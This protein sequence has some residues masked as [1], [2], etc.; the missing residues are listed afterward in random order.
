MNPD[1]NFV[2][3]GSDDAVVSESSPEEKRLNE[4]RAKYEGLISTELFGT[5]LFL[6]PLTWNELD[7]VTSRLSKPEKMFQTMAYVVDLCAV[8]PE[9]SAVQSLLRRYP[10]VVMNLGNKVLEAS[11]FIE[12][13]V[14]KY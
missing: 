5:T 3:D 1:E 2:T 13:E 7:Y 14:K 10:G 8:H 12:V 11:G 9:K 4:L 6:R